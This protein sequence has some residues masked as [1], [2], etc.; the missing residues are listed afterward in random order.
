MKVIWWSGSESMAEKILVIFPGALGDFVCFLPALRKLAQGTQLD[1]FARTEY[2]DLL[3]ATVKTSSFDRPEISS[4]F[5]PGVK[6]DEKLKRFF[7]SYAFIYSWMGSGQQEFVRNLEFL[8]N[9]NLGIFPFRPL[10][11]EMPMA[12]YYLSCVGEI[13]LG[14]IMPDIPLTPAALTWSA[15]FW[16]ESGLDGE[17]VLVLAPGSGANEKNWP[18]ESYRMV[19]KW[20]RKNMGGKVLIVFGPVEEDKMD[21]KSPWDDGLVVRDLSLAKVAALFTRCDLYLGNDSGV[22]HLAAAL[23]VRTVALFGPTNPVQ[24][25]PRGKRAA[26]ITQNVECSPC[27]HAV[28]KSCPHRKCLTTLSPVSVIGRLEEVIGLSYSRTGLLDMVGGRD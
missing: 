3:P 27:L 22:T 12:D 7:G 17:K 21:I 4:L 24:W 18:L 25:A 16:Q 9:G 2:A 1:L 13:S 23:G 10:S 19:A 26:V 20:W 28:M 8:S 6:R 15:R 11:Q 14:E 5:V